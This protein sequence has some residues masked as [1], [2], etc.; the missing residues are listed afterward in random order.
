MTLLALGHAGTIAVAA[1]TTRDIVAV[2]RHGASEPPMG[3]LTLLAGTG[4]VIFGLRSLEAVV[5]EATGQGYAAAIRRKL[6]L[7]MSRTP[8]IIVAQRRKGSMALRYVGDLNALKGWVSKGLA[9]LISAVITIPAAFAVLF[10]LHPRLAYGAAAPI[11]VVLLAILLLGVPLKRTH[12]ALRRRKARMAA[13]MTERLPQAL[14]LRRSGRLKTE[15]RGLAKRSR[16]ITEAAVLRSWLGETV[17]ALPEVAAATAAA[18][19]LG[20]SIRL[21][22]DIEDAVA[23]LTALTLIVWPLRRLAD[24]RD[25]F[26]GYR[27]A[28]KKL[29]DTLAGQTLPVKNKRDPVE[30]VPVLKVRNIQLPQWSEPLDF[31]MG[32]GEIWH[33]MGPPR[34]GKSHFLTVAAGLEKVASGTLEVCGLPSAAAR[35]GQI[36]YLGRFAPRLTG[37]L[38]RECTIGLGYKPDDSATLGAIEQAGLTPLCERLGGLSGLVAEDRQN[39]TSSEATAIYLVRGLLARPRLALVD[40]DEIG[41]GNRELTILF[42]HLNKVQASCLVSTSVSEPTSAM[43][44]ELFLPA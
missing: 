4:F 38:R 7:H 18:I 34:C 17:R 28:A 37:S 21:S 10:L 15:L 24:V 6:F 2:L 9:R 29:A 32:R 14:A 3:A 36:L 8:V 27:V 44:K 25:R 22:L 1:F 23:A 19:C 16:R 20:L 42:R 41:F 43:A 30:N 40:A 31:D 39:L 35:T 12:S 26:T 5:A 13:D 33:L 11:L